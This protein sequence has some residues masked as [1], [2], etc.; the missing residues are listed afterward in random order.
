MGPSSI[1]LV[2]MSI[3]EFQQP[4]PAN[5]FLRDR[6]LTFT[7]WNGLAGTAICFAALFPLWVLGATGAGDGKLVSV[8]GLML[9]PINGIGVIFVACMLA[10]IIIA[11][12]GLLRLAKS[13]CAKVG[14]QTWPTEERIAANKNPMA[15]YY[16]ARNGHCC[17]H[18][19]RNAVTKD[20]S[21][22]P[23]K[24]RQRNGMASVKA[25]DDFATF[26]VASFV[27]F[28]SGK[29]CNHRFLRGWQ[30][31]PGDPSLLTELVA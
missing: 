6:S 3:S 30:S 21:M 26:V 14:S 4:Q 31:L 9:G 13:S 11:A 19:V 22:Q 12:V 15:G 18:S 27:F 8:L 28:L 25:L 5:L 2:L 17:A 29:T 10:G 23:R 20:Q 16:S 24:K 7:L 1:A